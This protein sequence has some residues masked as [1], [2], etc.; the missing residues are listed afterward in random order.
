MKKTQYEHVQFH[1]EFDNIPEERFDKDYKPSEEVIEAY[2]NYRDVIGGRKTYEEAFPNKF[3]H[4]TENVTS[5]KRPWDPGYDA[6]TKQMKELREKGLLWS[7]KDDLDDA[8]IKE[9]QE[10]MDISELEKTIDKE[11]ASGDKGTID[12]EKVKKEFKDRF[13]TMSDQELLDALK[14]E[15]SNPGRGIAKMNYM[16][17]LREE[18]ERRGI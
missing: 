4:P 11:L 5:L 6:N 14:R 13:A 2:N 10:L 7:R 15:R 1:D 16:G 3:Y 12:R 9:I 8:T 17:L 18:M